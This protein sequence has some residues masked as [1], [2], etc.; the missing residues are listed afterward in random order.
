MSTIQDHYSKRFIDFLLQLFLVL[1]LYDTNIC[2]YNNFLTYNKV[3]DEP[4]YFGVPLNEIQLNSTEFKMCLKIDLSEITVAENNNK[5]VFKKR[6]YVT[7]CGDIL[8][9]HD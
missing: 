2:A 9:K 7:N 8:M 1:L 4:I 5:K 6:S 3:C